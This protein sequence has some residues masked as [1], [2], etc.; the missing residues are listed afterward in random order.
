MHPPMCM[1]LTGRGV[2]VKKELKIELLV[3]RRNVFYEHF[4]TKNSQECQTGPGLWRF[5]VCSPENVVSKRRHL[6]V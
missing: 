1:N 5:E 3:E 6:K 2:L 4:E